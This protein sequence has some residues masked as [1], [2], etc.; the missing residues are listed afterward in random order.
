MDKSIGNTACVCKVCYAWQ[1][2]EKGLIVMISCPYLKIRNFKGICKNGYKV[3]Q[4]VT[5]QEFTRASN[6]PV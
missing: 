2:G 1:E 3:N 5:A 6:K 4:R